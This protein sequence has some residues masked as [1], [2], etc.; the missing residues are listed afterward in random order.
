MGQWRVALELNVNT[1][2]EESFRGKH[3]WGSEIDS[4]WE[5]KEKGAEEGGKES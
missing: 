1:C 3:I 4:W 5:E 2:K